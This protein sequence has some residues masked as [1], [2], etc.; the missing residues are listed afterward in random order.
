MEKLNFHIIPS[1]AKQA[2]E[3]KEEK[4]SG[5]DY[6]SYGVDNLY[7]I[8]LSDLYDKSPVL[9]ACIDSVSDYVF[10]AG[11]TDETKGNT[12]VNKYGETFNDVLHKCVIDYISQG[13]MAM[14]LISNAYGKVIEIY[15]LDVRKVRL[16]ENGKKV[17]YN[18]KNWTKWSKESVT[19]ERYT[20]SKSKNSVFYFK[21]PA[22]KTFYGRPMWHSS[23]KSCM[24]DVEIAEFH[25]AAICNNFAASAVVNFNNGTPSE[26]I[27]DEI[28]NKL[29][30][31]FSGSENAAR[32]LV[33][34]NDDQT[35]AVTI[36]RLAEDN[37]DTKY[38]ALSKSVRNNILASFRISSALVGIMPEQTGFNAVEYESAW[39][40]YKPVVRGIQQEIVSA[41]SNVGIDIELTEYTI[42]FG[43]NNGEN[44]NVDNANT[45]ESIQ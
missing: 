4:V 38:D 2:P 31:K 19:Y 40:I 36:E 16:S 8:F 12:V 28:E 13:A 5:R 3:A 15:W 24:T 9:S 18:K 6:V 37:F 22:S 39:K 7:P 21:R 14:Q 41:F 43:D 32:L 10:A 42:D 35:H 26:E 17:Y 33:S 44:K 11:I 30:D 27:Q 20:G 25:Y 1:N 45:V 34:F 23:L 29:N